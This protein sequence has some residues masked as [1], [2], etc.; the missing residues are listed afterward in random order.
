MITS[1]VIKHFMIAVISCLVQVL[2][3]RSNDGFLQNNLHVTIRYENFICTRYFC[4]SIKIP[5]HLP[6]YLTTIKII[7]MFQIKTAFHGGRV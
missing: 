7:K 2:K 6:I 5:H 3:S 4:Q 1:E